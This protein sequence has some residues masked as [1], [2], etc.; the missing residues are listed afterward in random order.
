MKHLLHFTKRIHAYSG[1]I[2]Y[3]NLICMMLIG[4]LESVG[5]FLLIPLIGLTGILEFGTDEIAFLSWMTDLF[6]GMPETISLVII[7]G[8]YV[9]LMVGQSIFKRNQTILGAKIQQG[10]I[11]QLREETY[12]SLL[13]AKWGFYLKKRKSDIINIMTNETFNVSAGVHLFLQFVSS[14]VFTCIQIAIAFYLSVK[15]TSFI[16]VFGLILILFSKKFIR[17]SQT[18]GKE[19]CRVNR[20]VLSRYHGSL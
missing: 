7:L 11:R 18:L 12:R 13:Q 15:M 14:L 2:L 4:L 20:N 17:R 3:I 8:I 5:I 19:T 16:L 9:L 1:K 6:A 10:F